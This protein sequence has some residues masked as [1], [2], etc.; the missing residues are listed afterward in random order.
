M[1]DR[2]KTIEQDRGRA[3]VLDIVLNSVKILDIGEKHA[4]CVPIFMLST[5][6]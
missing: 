4:E 1:P 2:A 3:F 6:R 5:S